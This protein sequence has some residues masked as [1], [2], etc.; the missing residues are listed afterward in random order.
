LLKAAFL[1]KLLDTFN[2]MSFRELGAILAILLGCNGILTGQQSDSLRNFTAVVYDQSFRP[3]SSCHVINMTTRQGEVTDSLGIFRMPVNMTDTLLIRNIAF[4]DTLVAVSRIYFNRVIRLNWK[5]YP[6]EEARVFEWGSTYEDFREAII[7]MPNQ[8]T[9]GED[10][11]LP[12]QDPDHIPFDMDEE[13]LKSPA[14]ALSSPL[15][16]L[17]YNFSK[18]AKSARKVYWMKKNRL[19]HEKFDQIIAPENISRITGL[20]GQELQA[21]LAF[22]YQRMVCDF[23]CSEFQLYSEIHG[24]WDAYQLT[25]EK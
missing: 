1:T 4:K 21:F 25:N 11:G 18:Q 24:L 2:L 20:T 23:K 5:Y 6:L 22:L 8:Q 15:S 10:V 7:T 19:K 9:L 16:F 17:Y 13:V 14:F 12:R 3:L